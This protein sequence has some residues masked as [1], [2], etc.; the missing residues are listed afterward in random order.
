MTYLKALSTAALLSLS[1]TLN[2]QT[3]MLYAVGADRTMADDSQSQRLI[4]NEDFSNFT[5]GSESTPDSKNIADLRTGV[6]DAS[7]TA[8]PG[9]T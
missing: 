7:Y 8:A 9:W 4:V 5:D 1:V 3:A 6:I 2:A